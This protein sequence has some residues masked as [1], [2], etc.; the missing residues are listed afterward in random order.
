[1]SLRIVAGDLGGRR[2]EAPGG[3][4][5]RPTPERVR[6]AWFS[7]L[8]GRVAGAR[9]LDLFAGSGALGLEALSRGA[10][11]ATFVERSRRAASVLGANVRALQ[12]EDRCEIR[13][14]DVFSYLG[15]GEEDGPGEGGADG[16]ERWDLTLADPPYAGGDAPRLLERWRRDP[17]SEWLCLEHAS[18]GAGPLDEILGA[19][20]RREYGDTGLSFYHRDHEPEHREEP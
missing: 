12:V 9:V 2:I 4:R 20:W 18:D 5:T 3:R 16:G 14:T 6:E 10:R 7:A 11:R 19:A 13:V 17:F 1:M 8:H 15:D